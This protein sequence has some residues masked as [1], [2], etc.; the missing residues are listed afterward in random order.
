MTKAD[1]IEA[2]Y[3]QIGDFT[4]KESSELVEVVFVEMKKAL[5]QG[6]KLKVSGFG[7]FIIRGKNERV[8]RN[9]QTGEP[10]T[11]YSRRVLTFKPSQVLKAQLNAEGSE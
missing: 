7:N 1:I 4:K 3:D 8:G 9:P 6:R 2:V 5:S 10:I 11:I